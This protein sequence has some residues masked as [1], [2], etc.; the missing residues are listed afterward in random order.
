M[1]KVCIVSPM[2]LSL[3][4]RVVKEADALSEAGYEVS[5][6]APS[7]LRW[8]HAADCTFQTRPWQRIAA[9]WFGPNAPIVDRVRE[10]FERSSAAVALC[11]GS[12]RP[13]FLNAALHPATH[14]LIRTAISVSARLFIGHYPAG[15]V[16]AARAAERYGASFAFDAEDYHLGDLEDR[17][18]ND[19]VREVIHSIESR[20]LAS[21]A[22]VSAAAPLIADA[23]K[24]AYRLKRPSVILNVFPRE[25]SAHSPRPRKPGFRKSLYWFSQ[26]IGP[27]RGLECAID[28]IALS[29]SRPF[30][31]LRGAEQTNFVRRLK[32]RAESRGVRELL[33]ILPLE[34]P[35]EMERL[36]S[37]HDAGF[38]GETGH[39]KN[40]QIMLTNKQFSYLLAG[41]PTILS[42]IPSHRDFVEG[43]EGAAMLY[44]TENPGSLALAIDTLFNDESRRFAMAKEAWRLGQERFNWDMEKRKFLELVE[45]ALGPRSLGR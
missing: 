37:Q 11:A 26:T 27:D 39:S 17:P 2:H 5:I 31:T 7:Y 44:Q 10:T 6:V 30:L 23:Y 12:R 14:G 38:V 1:I 43:A 9:P 13:Y 8:A 32:A 15:L 25:Q 16:A 42:D 18:E 21:A 4:P 45:T 33:R 40:R 3:N 35:D 20:H 24:C 22:Y 36:A 28:A 19:R 41:L 29:Q 34:A